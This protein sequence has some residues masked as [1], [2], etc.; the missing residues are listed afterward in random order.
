[1]EKQLKTYVFVRKRDMVEMSEPMISDENNNP[2]ER[3][4]DS[5]SRFI[6]AIDELVVRRFDA[7]AGWGF[8]YMGGLYN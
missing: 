8:G 4:W 7:F 5:S 3:F 1:M 6:G 2:E